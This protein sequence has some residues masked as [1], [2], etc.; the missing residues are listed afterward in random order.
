MDITAYSSLTELL[1][2]S[3]YVLRFI[4]NSTAFADEYTNLQSKG[5]KVRCLALVRQLRL[6]LD[7]KGIIRCGG[8]IHNAPVSR[9]TKF[10]SL[11]PKEHPLTKLIVYATHKEQLHAGVNSTVAALRQAYWIPS[12]R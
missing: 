8:R 9:S 5:S 11:L 1:H 4:F 12:A 2:I 10:P 3:A 7:E 6:F